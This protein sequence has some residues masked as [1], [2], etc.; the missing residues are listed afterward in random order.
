MATRFK[1]FL[2]SFDLVSMGSLM[3][4]AVTDIESPFRLGASN[5]GLETSPWTKAD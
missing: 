3:I 1:M 4:R 5:P 2:D